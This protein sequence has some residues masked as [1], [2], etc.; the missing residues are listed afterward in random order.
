MPEENLK[1]NYRFEHTDEDTGRRIM[2]DFDVS[3]IAHW[4]DIHTEFCRFLSGVYGFDIAKA[5]EYQYNI[6]KDAF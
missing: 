6:Q 2:F 4:S 1:S 5:L 3:S